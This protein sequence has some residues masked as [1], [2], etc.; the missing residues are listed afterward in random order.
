MDISDL[1]ASLFDVSEL[2]LKLN[3]FLSSS[4]LFAFFSG[5]RPM[6]RS[7]FPSVFWFSYTFSASRFLFDDTF[8]N[9]IVL[10]RRG[11]QLCLLGGHMGL[12]R[13]VRGSEGLAT[14][15][16]YFRNFCK[17][18]R[19][20]PSVM[21]APCSLVEFYRRFRGACCLHHQGADDGGFPVNS[22]ISS[23]SGD[24]GLVR[25]LVHRHIVTRR[26]L[27]P[28]LHYRAGLCLRTVNWTRNREIIMCV[29][30]SVFYRRICR[31]DFDKIWYWVSTLKVSY[32]F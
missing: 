31:V 17:S 24:L 11:G 4:S 3:L 27:N 28:V 7:S 13:S 6:P 16:Q 18:W 5:C 19:W 26:R 29:R 1:D 21:L 2:R 32:R 25:A 15:I 20:L 30:P 10:C 23:P 22:G 14:L 12:F 9:R 8:R